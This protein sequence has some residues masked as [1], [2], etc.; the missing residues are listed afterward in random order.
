MT[1]HGRFTFLVN[2]GIRIAQIV[3]RKKQNVVFEKVGKLSCNACGS[4][5]F[6]LTGV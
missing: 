4:G 2:V 5:S 3:F 6:G 1:N